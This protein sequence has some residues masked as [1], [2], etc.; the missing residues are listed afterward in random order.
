MKIRLGAH[1]G[2]LTPCVSH[3]Q[4]WRSVTKALAYSILGVKNLFTELV[5]LDI[6]V[7]FCNMNFKKAVFAK[8]FKW[9][10]LEFFSGYKRKI[11]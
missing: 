6:F 1:S 11:L 5:K 8:H 10:Y 2:R 7:F 9:N 4:L 3:C